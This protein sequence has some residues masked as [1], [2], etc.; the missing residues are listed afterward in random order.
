[1]FGAKT[2]AMSAEQSPAVLNFLADVVVNGFTRV[3][4][5]PFFLVLDIYFAKQRVRK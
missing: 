1:M 3:I 4:G 5:A 2:E